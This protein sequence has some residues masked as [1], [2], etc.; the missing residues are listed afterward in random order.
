MGTKRYKGRN[1][2]I[3]LSIINDLQTGCKVEAFIGQIAK[4]EIRLSL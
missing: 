4:R 1:N 2:E 3:I